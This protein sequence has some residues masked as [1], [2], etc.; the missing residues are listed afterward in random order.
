MNVK[1][2]SQIKPQTDEVSD[3][4]RHRNWHMATG[5]AGDSDGRR[6]RVKNRR[7]WTPRSRPYT[8]WTHWPWS[9]QLNRCRVVCVSPRYTHRVKKKSDLFICGAPSII[10]YLI[11]I[12]C[13]D[14]THEEKWISYILKR[15]KKT[16]TCT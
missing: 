13:Y 6:R 9:N 1:M 5:L 11:N 10:Y 8:G 16:T 4:S 3:T 14:M 7:K 15:K 2:W 12:F